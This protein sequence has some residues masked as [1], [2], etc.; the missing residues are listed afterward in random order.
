MAQYAFYFDQSRCNGCMACANACK[1]WNQLAP[2]P[3]KW[4]RIQQYETGSFPNLRLNNAFLPCFQCANPVCVPAANGALFKEPKY[5]AVLMD[6]ARAT[7]SSMKAAWQACPYGSIAFDSDSPN[8]NASKCTMCVDRLQQ[9]L[10]PAC[11]V[12]CPMRALDFGPAD[13]LAKKYPNAQTELQD[14]PASSLTRPSA[15]FKPTATKKA[16]VPYDAGKAL[17]LLG[18]RDPLP[19]VFT[20]PTQVTKVPAGILG[21][22]SLTL[23]STSTKQ[24]MHLTRSEDG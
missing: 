23:K 8:S 16:I 21:R 2:G 1:S 11:V 6:P 10:L 15:F 9:N 14:Y 13:V 19:A 5:G 17:T 22:G 18:N 4:L 24:L 12:S 3:T 7:D 20:D